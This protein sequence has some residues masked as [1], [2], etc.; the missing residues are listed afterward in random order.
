[1]VQPIA[2]NALT[3]LINISSD[4]EALKCLAEDDAFIESVLSR[5]TVSCLHPL[6]FGIYHSS[7]SFAYLDFLFFFFVILTSW[8]SLNAQQSPDAM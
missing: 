1:M 4:V 8:V 5:V 7:S 6:L 2:K 3:I